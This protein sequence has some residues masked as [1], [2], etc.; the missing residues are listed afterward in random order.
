MRGKITRVWSRLVSVSLPL[1]AVMLLT[2]VAIAQVQSTPQERANWILH[3]SDWE[4]ASL[5]GDPPPQAESAGSTAGAAVAE[6]GSRRKGSPAVPIF[7]SLVLPGAGEAYLGY[8]R[9]Y[10]LMALD[11]A[12]W[13]G[14]VHH[15]DQGKQIREDYIKFAEEHWDEERLSAAYWSNHPDEYLA[16]VGIPYFP[17]VGDSRTAYTNLP[18]WVSREDDEREYFENLGKWDQFVFGWDD[19]VRPEELPGYIGG[20]AL[21]DLRLPGIADNREIYRSMRQES[22]DQFTKRDRLIYLNIATRLISMVQ[23]AYL[24]GLFG[25]GSKSELTVAGHP[26]SLIAEPR[27]LTAT[28]VGFAV[29]Y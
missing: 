6:E 11:I 24:Q 8:K 14:V 27:G 16:G 13:I 1:L 26:V 15:N 9:G 29:A 12:L 10:F 2:S 17:D 7:M 18:L 3:R 28:R 20:G 25:G 22:N 4:L 21:S 19:F 23:V 5:T